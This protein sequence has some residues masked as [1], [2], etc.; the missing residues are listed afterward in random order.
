MFKLP[1][2]CKVD[3]FIPKKAFYEN[4]NISTNIKNSFVSDIEKITWLY[5]LSPDTIGISMT[6]LVQKIQIFEIIIKKEEVPLKVL[7]IIS[8][9]VKYPI[10]FIVKYQNDYCF[11]MK[12]DKIYSSAWNEQIKFNFFALNLKD[13]Y[14]SMVK[15]IINQDEQASE[16]EVLVSKIAAKEILINNIT[17]LENRIKKEKQFNRKSELNIELNKLRKEMENI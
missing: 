9:A 3:K 14:E 17:M 8:K 2:S 6:E 11:A 16:L 1:A 5:K 7:E 12:Y 10:L 13:L 15:V 4:I